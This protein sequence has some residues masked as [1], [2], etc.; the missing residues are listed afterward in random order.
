MNVGDVISTNSGACRV[1]KYETR[2]RVTVTFI[3]TGYTKTTSTQALRRGSVK[4]P[5]F[6]SIRG[7]AC[8]GEG[9]FRASIHSRLTPEYKLYLSVTTRCYDTEFQQKNPTYRK[10]RLCEDWLNF[11]TFARDVSQMKNFG[12]RGFDL[13]KDLRILGNKEYG[14]SACSFIPHCINTVLLRREAEG[15]Y[16]QDGGGF[17]TKLRMYNENVYLGTFK[18]KRKAMSIYREAKSEYVIELANTHRKELHPEVY[19]NL[20]NLN[21]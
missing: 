4:D 5:Y 10:C 9:K 6:P 15:V 18:S 21:W 20:V 14:P 8:L 1:T 16:L 12:R 13:D 17:L 7:V 3:D 2:L 19:N 11:Q